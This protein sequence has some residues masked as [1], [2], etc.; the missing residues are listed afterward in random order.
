MQKLVNYPDYRVFLQDYYQHQKKE[1]GSFTFASFAK[2]A[3]LGSANYLQMVIKGRRNLTISNIHGFAHALG[4]DFAETNYFE[5]LVLE[6]QAQGTEE[7]KFYRNR[8]KELK[9]KQSSLS[10]GEVTRTKKTELLESSVTTA[11]ALLANRQKAEK[12]FPL[13]M[14]KLSL[15][16]AQVKQA[17]EQLKKN[18]VFE[19]KNGVGQLI[20]KHTMVSDPKGVS[21]RLR[22]FLKSGLEENLGV[23]EKR[24]LAGSAKFLSL[25]FTAPEES[26]EEMFKAVRSSSEKLTKDF[27]PNVEDD[28]GV[29]RLQVQLYR[30]RK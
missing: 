6:N 19:F 25:L 11:V 10:G 12:A 9:Q 24:Y 3:N 13:C 18:E 30:Y 4:L 22:Q 15:T 21:L 26:L 28:A 8:L 2:K 7:K 20:H 23:F 29:Y 17:F 16:E 27:D 1:L 5:A 14:K